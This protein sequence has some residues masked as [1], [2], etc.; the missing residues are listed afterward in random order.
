[1]KQK[2]VT[3]KELKQIID[4]ALAEQINIK[5]AVDYSH[6][7]LLKYIDSNGDSDNLKKYLEKEA[8]NDDK[9]L[10]DRDGENKQTDKSTKSVKKRKQK[11]KKSVKK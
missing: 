11:S 1:M 4:I 2:K 6:T 10:R 5:R 7:L 3:Y 9:T 8:K